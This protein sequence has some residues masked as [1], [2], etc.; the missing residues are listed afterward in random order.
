LKSKTK[1]K[2]KKQFTKVENEVEDS[3][4]DFK[5]SVKRTFAEDEPKK[6][7]AVAPEPKFIE[8]Q[9]CKNNCKCCEHPQ[10][11]TPGITGHVCTCRC[12][13]DIVG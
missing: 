4:D 1:S 9:C 12:H 11:T 8:C 5:K 6:V 10:G 13:A 7:K 3:F 2:F